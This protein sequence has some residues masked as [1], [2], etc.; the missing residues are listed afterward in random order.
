VAA[1][2]VAGCLGDSRPELRIQSGAARLH[3]AT[4]EYLTDGLAPGGEQT[5]YAAAIPDRAPD[6]V[7]PDA[8]DSLAVRLRGEDGDL[9]HLVTQ[10]RSPPAGPLR[11]GTDQA[12]AWADGA[13][14]LTTTAEPA[15]PDGQLATADELVYTA[16]WSVEPSLAELPEAELAVET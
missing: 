12:V 3:A 1:A 8:P 13:V 4:D 11:F 7:G 9:F 15:E 10:L 2:G 5:T 6:A 16:V 14:R